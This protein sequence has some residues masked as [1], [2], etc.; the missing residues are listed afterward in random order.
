VRAAFAFDHLDLNPFLADAKKKRTKKTA[1]MAGADTPTPSARPNAAP[2]KDWFKRP[3]TAK[4]KKAGVPPIVAAPSAPA[5]HAP[6][7]LPAVPP[8]A[9]MATPAAFDADVNLN[10]RKAR[11]GHIDI[12]PSSLSLVFRDGVMNANLGGM[13]L[14]GG[15]ASGT[16]TIDATKPIP[17]FTGNLRL[18]GVQ[19][20]PLLSDAAQFSMIAGRTKLALDVSGKGDNAD[21]IKSSLRGHGSVVVTDGFIEGIDITAFIEGLGEGDFNLRQGP[22]AKTAFSD[23]GGGFTI[24]EGIVETNDLEMASPLLKVTAEGSVDLPRGTLDI[25]AHPEIL[26]GPEG[27]SGANVLAGLSVPVRIEGP[28]KHPRI[29][30]QIGGVFADPESASKAVNQIGSALQKKFKGKPLGETIGRFLGNVQ[31]GGTRRGQPARKKRS[32]QAQ[33]APRS[34]EPEKSGADDGAM[35][36][37]LEEIL[38]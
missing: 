33:S 30:P 31:I 13:E 5:G 22:D 17:A 37:D 7:A 10:I 24:A 12:G 27:K 18:E 21:E 35:D 32:P 1:P 4:G 36:P 25:L 2:A 15:K 16:L 8:A 19:A 6:T 11:F 26:K 29:K 38:R 14:Y 3:D 28:L 9:P 23:L 34:A 20:K